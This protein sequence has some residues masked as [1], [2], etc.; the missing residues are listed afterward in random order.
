MSFRLLTFPN[1]FEQSQYPYFVSLGDAFLHG[2]LDL[3]TPPNVAYDLSLFAGR[4]YLYWPPFPALLFVPLVAI[5]GSGVSDVPLTVA[6]GGLD[7]ALVS[8][9]LKAMDARGMASLSAEKRAWLTFFFAFGTVHLTLAPYASIWFTSELTAFA[10][11]CGAYLAT[12]RLEGWSTPLVAGSLVAAA[13]L[14]RSSTPFAA[15]WIA[16]YLLRE[17]NRSERLAPIRIAA[18]GLAPVLLA[19][20]LLAVYNFLRFGNPLDNGI[21]YH[22]MNEVF[23]A[24]YASYGYLNLHYLPT[25][26]YYTLVAIPYLAL[27][28]PNPSDFFMG[29]SL[30]LLSPVFFLAILGVV[31]TFRRHGWALALSCLV[32]M[33]PALVLMGTGWAEFGPRYTLDVTVPL[34]VA[35][36]L[37]AREV[38]TK[39]LSR[40]TFVSLLMYVPGTIWL[41]AAL[42]P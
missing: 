29:G 24:D 32:G 26:L 8:M 4:V 18:F 23:R 3:Q 36:A 15:I 9:L 5:F 39:T 7:V 37:G 13:F 10:L 27:L 22:Q 25:N 14:S 6:M 11:L 42:R 31:R 17:R 30:F 20:G 12:L 41:G 2:R 1:P 19:A 33:G 38:G 40:L 35:T 16:W 28:G 34:L 21:A